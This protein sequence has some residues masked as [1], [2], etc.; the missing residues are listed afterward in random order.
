[1]IQSAAAVVQNAPRFVKTGKKV[2]RLIRLCV[3][4]LDGTL[5]HSLQDLADACNHALRGNG[6]A[7]H[8][9]ED[10]RYFVGDGIRRLIERVL[11]ENCRDELTIARIKQD[12]DSYYSAH[13]LDAT[14]PYP[15]IP[16]MLRQLAAREVK[17]AVVSNKPD[18][19]ARAIVTQV[20]GTG[21]FCTVA[22]KREGYKVKPDPRALLEILEQ[23]RVPHSECLY[24]GDSG[25]DIQ[26]A[27]NAGVRSVGVCWGFRPVGEL[28]NAGADYLLHKPEELL[29]ILENFQ[30]N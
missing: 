2:V 8:P 11:P 21:V 5:I 26:T 16:Q 3:F 28:T 17:I 7:A 22:G 29:L 14:R 13:C 9:V 12:F 24:I 30:N 15:G 25:V 10:Y 27:Q 18:A 19:F 20:F 4:D 6:F 1:M 23:Q